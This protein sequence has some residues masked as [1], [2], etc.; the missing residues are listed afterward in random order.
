MGIKLNP[1]YI[2]GSIAA[3]G[4]GVLKIPFRLNR[5]V[6]VD[7]INSMRVRVKTATTNV[8]KEALSSTAIF[9]IY[10]DYYEATFDVGEEV[11]NVGQHYKIQLAF[12]NGEGEEATVGHYSSVGVF[13]YT[14]TP[15]ISI[16]IPNLGGQTYI[17]ICDLTK[18]VTEKIYNYEFIVRN[19]DGEIVESSGEKI[20]KNSNDYI[21]YASDEYTVQTVFGVD[22]QP[23]IEYKITTINGLTVSTTTSIVVAESRPNYLDDLYTF[24]ASNDYDNGRILLS[25]KLGNGRPNLLRNTAANKFN[26][27]QYTNASL[28][29]SLAR[30]NDSDLG[31]EIIKISKVGGGA[32]VEETWGVQQTDILLKPNTTYTL[33]A[34]IKTV[35]EYQKVKFVVSSVDTEVIEFNKEAAFL[36][37]PGNVWA[38]SPKT[39]TFTTP[40]FIG[41]CK[42]KCAFYSST[43]MI[44]GNINPSLDAFYL[45]Q[46]KLEEGGGCS[47]WQPHES[48]VISPYDRGYI[49][50]RSSSDSDFTLW[51]DIAKFV[52]RANSLF[53]PCVYEDYTVEHG[54]EYKYSIQV[55]NN[56]NERSDRL[57][58][59]AI[60]CDFEDLFLYDGQRQLKIR[61]NPKV[62]SFKTTTLETKVDTIGGQYPFFFRNGNVSYKDFPISGL[63]S[64]WMDENELFISNAQL[65]LIN[66]G[67]EKS[68][69]FNEDDLN[70]A[71]STHL[72]AN[73]F[74]AERLFKTEVLNW[75]NNG[76]VKLFKSPAEGSFIVRLMNVSMSPNDTVSRMLHSFNANAYEVAAF[77]FFN[78]N[79]YNFIKPLTNKN[80]T[81]LTYNTTDPSFSLQDVYYSVYLNDVTPGTRF[82]Y[83]YV[84]NP[85]AYTYIVPSY[86]IHK[87]GIYESPLNYLV[88]KGNSVQGALT[89][90]T[91]TTAPENLYLEESVV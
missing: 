6:S 25:L 64:Y 81:V 36:V 1:P 5:T 8:W 10:G 65:N 61:Y 51:N 79:K 28:Y 44:D 82:E 41:D 13:K 38:E 14:A 18:D 15:T 50:S 30:Q 49:I 34:N 76:E 55:Y 85:K 68:Y 40:N 88:Q 17:G 12:V 80:N 60:Y 66:T 70:L 67:I 57:L 87:I 59:N 4:G 54:I 74:Y 89:Y 3:Q 75:L 69:T 33:S 90:S 32:D 58:S 91:Y 77:N 62:T 37:F 26:W 53:A 84:N 20:H 2:E 56:N 29:S 83:K 48:E 24:Y 9:N 31:S 22:E 47:E 21:G 73:N 71:R 42:F 52:V 43:L 46:S 16:Q 39:F 7:D 72:T 86:D 19:T 23:T 78:L 11:L 27:Q 35:A 63:V 45:Y